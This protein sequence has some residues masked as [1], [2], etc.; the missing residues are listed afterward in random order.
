MWEGGGRVSQYVGG[1]GRAWNVGSISLSF[2][3]E[4][5]PSGLR[6]VKVVALVVGGLVC[7]RQSSILFPF[8]SPTHN[9]LRG[10][11]YQPLTR[12]LFRVGSIWIN[13]ESRS[14]ATMAIFSW[15]DLIK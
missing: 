2:L 15:R 7:S 3:P 5:K 6:K 8:E 14:L 1:G 9:F 11:I 10:G 4:A 12:F 13:Q